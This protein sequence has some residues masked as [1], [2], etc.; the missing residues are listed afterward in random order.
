[1]TR[2]GRVELYR[3][4]NAARV[5]RRSLRAAPLL[6][7]R[8]TTTKYHYDGSSV[9]EPGLTLMELLPQSINEALLLRE[10]CLVRECR[11]EFTLFLPRRIVS[12]HFAGT[13]S[14]GPGRLQGSDS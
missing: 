5:R 2:S 13:Q 8:E 11:V 9:T 10:A 6:A 7:F 3:C 1:M 14:A 4:S 12:A